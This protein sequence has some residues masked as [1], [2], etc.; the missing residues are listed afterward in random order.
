MAAIAE[1]DAPQQTEPT[2]AES[3]QDEPV[4]DEKKVVI[5]CDGGTVNIRVGNDTK[6]A[7]ITAA[8]GGTV[9]SYVATAENGWHAVIVGDRVGWVSGKYSRIE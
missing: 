7:R 4:T 9:L 1:K 2:P 5:T 6:Y 8:E 3:P